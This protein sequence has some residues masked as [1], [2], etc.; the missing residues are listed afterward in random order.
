MH[1][2]LTADELRRQ[3]KRRGV[4]LNTLH[5]LLRIASLD[6]RRPDFRKERDTRI[7]KF[8][9][10]LEGIR[11]P[12][13]VAIARVPQPTVWRIVEGL[14]TSGAVR[15]VADYTDRS[16]ARRAKWLQ[17]PGSPDIP[18]AR[19]AELV[20]TAELIKSYLPLWV[21]EH[22][23]AQAAKVAP[24]APEPPP[25]PLPIRQAQ[26]VPR[27]EVPDPTIRH[28]KNDDQLPPPVPAPVLRPPIAPAPQ[29]EPSTNLGE[30]RSQLVDGFGDDRD[31]PHTVAEPVP[32]P[33]YAPV[34][35]PLVPAPPPRPYV[36]PAS[37]PAPLAA[38]LGIY[39]PAAPWE[40]PYPHLPPPEPF[41]WG[42]AGK[43]GLGSVV[44]SVL[45]TIVLLFG[46]AIWQW[47]HAWG[48]TLLWFGAGSSLV[49]LVL[50]KGDAWWDTFGDRTPLISRSTVALGLVLMFWP[51]GLGRWT[52]QVTGALT[53]PVSMPPAAPAAPVV[54]P[55]PPSPPPATCG[56]ARVTAPRGLRLRSRAGLDTDIV[57]KLPQGTLVELLC[58]FEDRG[59]IRWVLVRVDGRA[60]WVAA[61]EGDAVYLVRP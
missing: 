46:V 21:A 2:H 12:D 47:T 58:P 49:G 33:L 30:I 25:P 59:T 44:V 14:R 23:A 17:P 52:W 56:P 6:P 45:I 11:E 9:V 57:G 37:Y 54:H 15:V 31:T 43:M 26:A 36:P 19:R 4:H 16:I 27:P 61:A 55:A 39:T 10:M 8:I 42:F 29:V 5:A 51:T 38:P 28:L 3:L 18:D 41:P 60:G 34:H 48:P 50:W 7:R 20:E 13:L 1:N 35:Y 53:P 40:R 22:A 32:Q 24:A